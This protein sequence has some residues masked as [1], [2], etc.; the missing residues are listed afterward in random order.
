MGA[1]TAAGTGAG[2]TEDFQRRPELERWF[3]SDLGRALLEAEARLLADPCREHA[4]H[5]L[6]L[7]MVDATDLVLPGDCY[8]SF[9]LAPMR[10]GGSHGCVSAYEALPLAEGS[11]D[12]VVV[13]NV[14]E[15]SDQP[16]QILRE[17]ERVLSPGG[18]LLVLVLNPWSLLG[19]KAWG[20][21]RLGA[22]P[23]RMQRISAHRLH[24]WMSLLGLAV[25]RVR[26]DFYQFPM[27]HPRL[28]RLGMSLRRR[29]RP[30]SIPV[31]GVYLM[32]AVKETTPLI[33][34]RPRL[35]RWRSGF[36]APG[37]AH[38]GLPAS[39]KLH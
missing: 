14:L 26:Y 4:I 18:R 13:Q 39:R 31:G 27:D 23:W 28:L 17:A 6:V 19:L 2:Q 29:L 35:V 8:H 7:G 12:S 11:M 10:R 37:L 20:Q 38:G 1:G 9:S 21:Y 22:L 32:E 3:R 15:F 25:R 33:P 16:H 34:V 24:D 5:R 30:A 36:V